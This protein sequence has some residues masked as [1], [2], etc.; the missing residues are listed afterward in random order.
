MPETDNQLQI[1]SSR[2]PAHRVLDTF[3]IFPR[4]PPEIRTQI[5]ELMIL[6]RRVLIGQG[7][8]RPKLDE[9]EGAL[10]FVNWETK[11]LFD[12]E[13]HKLFLDPELQPVYFNSKLDTLCLPDGL[14]ALENLSRDYAP[15]LSKIKRIEVAEAPWK[16]WSTP[17]LER[18]DLRCMGSDS[19]IMV[20]RAVDELMWQSKRRD[21]KFTIYHLEQL[22]RS[23]LLH[24]DPSIPY[25]GPK[26]A[27]LFSTKFLDDG[28]YFQTTDDLSHVRYGHIESYSRHKTHRGHIMVSHDDS[29]ITYLVQDAQWDVTHWRHPATGVPPVWVDGEW[30]KPEPD[31]F[32][33]MFLLDQ[34]DKTWK[35]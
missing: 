6:P 33:K 14:D 2:N 7:H 20:R 8:M 25:S 3:R 27:A 32:S 9:V 5:W 21:G 30:V 15:C 13:Y 1:G 28:F 12:R 11:T 18:M 16:D 19:I 31:V 35:N 34:F 23:L 24:A 29:E 10:I 22:K 17:Q 26:L 4:L